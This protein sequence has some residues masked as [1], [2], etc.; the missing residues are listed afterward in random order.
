MSPPGSLLGLGD[1][2]TPILPRAAPTAA[3]P[4][5]APSLVPSLPRGAAEAHWTPRTLWQGGTRAL[6]PAGD[7]GDR[8]ALLAAFIDSFCSNK[9]DG[10]EIKTKITQNNPNPGGRKGWGKRR[11]L[12][13]LWGCCRGGQAAPH[14]AGEPGEA[15]PAGHRGLSRTDRGSHR[16]FTP[17]RG[18]APT[19]PCSPELS[20][21]TAM[22]PHRSQSI[23]PCPARLAPSPASPIPTVRVS[24]RVRGSQMGRGLSVPASLGSASP[25]LSGGAEG[26]RA[27]S[28]GPGGGGLSWGCG[29]G[30]LPCCRS[31][32]TRWT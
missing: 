11:V 4:G 3:G 9:A 20:L 2:R 1:P 15:S 12:P 21:L 24:S 23:P 7:M 25:S 22:S 29:S 26:G 18:L 31:P 27:Q 13:Q 16:T 8:P 6:F 30:C 5:A 14:R 28:C 32:G 10:A 17:G 19:P